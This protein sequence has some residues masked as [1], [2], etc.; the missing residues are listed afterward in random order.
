MS[1]NRDFNSFAL[2]FLK[3]MNEK[4]SRFKWLKPLNVNKIKN[5]SFYEKGLSS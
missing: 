2:G 4:L 5:T 3:V 1:Y